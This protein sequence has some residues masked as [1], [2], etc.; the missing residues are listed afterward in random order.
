MKEQFGS[1]F[2][3]KTDWKALFQKDTWFEW[4]RPVERD[5]IV[6]R[7]FT[8]P[9]VFKWYCFQLSIRLIILI[10]IPVLHL[11]YKY[12][13]HWSEGYDIK[14][15]SMVMLNSMPNIKFFR[16]GIDLGKENG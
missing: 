13:N 4:N 15:V 8:I 2:N 14:F 16:M 1:K 12:W 5:E 6:L 10:F 11:S 7:R 9:N 3:L